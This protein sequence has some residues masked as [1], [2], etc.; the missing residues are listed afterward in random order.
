M[1]IGLNGRL[2]EEEEAVISVFDHGFMYGMGCFETFRTYGGR[3][4]LFDAHMDRLEASL[5][6]VGI[7]A[8]IDRPAARAL[9]GRLIEANGFA[10]AYVRYAVSAGIGPLGLPDDEYAAPHTIIYTKPLPPAADGGEPSVRP[11][12]VLRL[13]R[14]TPEGERRIK[15]FH[16][17]NNILGKRELGRYP[18]AAG[19]EGLFL[20]ADG[21]VAEG[22]VS[23]VFFVIDGRVV[24]PPTNTGILAGVTRGFVL[25][26]SASLGIPAAEEPLTLRDAARAQ[27]VFLTNSVQEIVRVDRIYDPDGA[28]I[29][30]SPGDGRADTAGRLLAAYRQAVKGMMNE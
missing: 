1:K 16:F 6:E 25:E 20:T 3:P 22:V 9:I 27:E 14:N 21:L 26:L 10:D 28:V 8:R 17:M 30:R 4:F 23:N 18:W 15:S 12:Q 2:V 19:A 5:R 13:R 11:L 29:W 7:A 24:T